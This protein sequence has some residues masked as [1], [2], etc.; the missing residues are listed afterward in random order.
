MVSAPQMATAWCAH[1]RFLL[2]VYV[3]VF[4][5]V[6]ISLL[7]ERLLIDVFM[8][9]VNHAFCLSEDGSAQSH[10]L[11]ACKGI[12]LVIGSTCFIVGILSRI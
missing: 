5:G 4:K 12:S 3:C 9:V 8:L 1:L 7:Y 2:T 11:A 6:C 10:L